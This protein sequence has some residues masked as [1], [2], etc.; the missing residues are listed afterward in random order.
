MPASKASDSQA[1][2]SLPSDV[3]SE[4][5]PQDSIPQN[6]PCVG[7][8]SSR[9]ELG[10]SFLQGRLPLASQITGTW[11]EIGDV[12]NDPSPV[13]RSLNCSGVKRGSKFEFVLIASGYSV[14]LH[15]VGMTY[16]QKVTMEPNRMGY[17]EFPVD[18]SADEGPDIYRCRLTK[19]GTLAC[20]VH[21]Y[22]GVEF[23][24]MMV[25]KEQIYEVTQL[26]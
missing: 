2:N 11:V 8:P 17:V 16:P 23:K 6:A 25:E 22:R 21:A 9:T 4:E 24:K 14:E 3:S 10:K 12:A 15:E 26:P 18:L 20:L 13:H 7:Q 19:R 1:P 5:V